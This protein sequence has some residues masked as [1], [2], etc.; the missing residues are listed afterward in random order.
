MSRA[1]KTGWPLSFTLL[2]GRAS[3][4]LYLL[5]A[6]VGK[7]RGGV[8]EFYKNGFL[9]L[10]PP[11]L[12]EWFASPYGHAVPFMEVLVGAMLILGWVGRLWALFAVL[13]ITSFTIAVYEAGMFFKGAGPFHVNVI[14]I[15]LALILVAA[16]PGRI[17]VD[18][19][20]RREVKNTETASSA[21]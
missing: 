14:L 9:P 20:R 3:L 10:K 18:G 16:G 8:E 13:A 1:G 2:L 6:G 15:A 11:W 5:L 7:I 19:F 4:G 17:S 21:A 12:P